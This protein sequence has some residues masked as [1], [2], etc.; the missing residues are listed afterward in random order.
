[1]KRLLLCC[2]SLTVLP[3]PAPAR[4][5]PR[6]ELFG[7]YSYNRIE[8]VSS[9][10]A[11]N[12]N[13]WH[14]SL[15][16]NTRIVGFVADFSGHY[17]ETGPTRVSTFSAM[18]G[19][20]FVYHGKRVAWFAQS[21][22][23]VSRIGVGSNGLG[24]VIGGPSDAAFAFVPGGGGLDIKLGDKVALRVFEIDVVFSRWGDVTQ[25][26]SR[27]STGIVFRFGKN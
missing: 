8:S 11:A 20:R 2:V 16:V 7:G 15:A 5:A 25:V 14:A 27:L 22:Y 23:G 10:E 4:Q 12:T 19:P 9:L 17:G 26:Q 18:F 1:M 6:A 3:V 21:L 24:S 13:G